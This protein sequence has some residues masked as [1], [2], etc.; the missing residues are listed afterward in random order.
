MCIRDRIAAITFLF[1]L[2]SIIFALKQP[3]LYRSEVLLA[4]AE[5][6]NNGGL[7]ALAGQFGGL[8]SLAGVNIG[9]QSTNKTQLA[10]E[11]LKSRKFVSSFIEKHNILPD[12]MAVKSWELNK[13]VSYDPEVYDSNSKT[14]LREVEAPLTSKPSEQEACLLYTSDAADE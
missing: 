7:S 13:G 10:L 11:V 3:N 12:L 6:K 4:P 5:A 2:F 9:G 14:W 1:V 8:A